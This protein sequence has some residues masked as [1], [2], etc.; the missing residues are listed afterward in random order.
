MRFWLN[1]Y[2][3]RFSLHFSKISYNTEFDDVDKDCR[4]Q[5]MAG[6]YMLKYMD[7]SIL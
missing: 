5:L 4:I 3:L 6:S 1:P 2:L 7:M